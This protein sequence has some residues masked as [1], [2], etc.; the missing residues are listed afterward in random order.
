MEFKVGDRVRCIKEYVGKIPLDLCGTVM[1][2]GLDGISVGVEWDINIGGHDGELYFKGKAGYCY[3]IPKYCIKNITEKKYPTIII[4][5]DG[6]T[7][8]AMLRQ[9]KEVIR[10][11]TAKCNPAD[12]FDY[13]VGARLALDRLMQVETKSVKVATVREVKRKAK[14]GEW[15]K[16]TGKGDKGIYE[17]GDVLKVIS[18]HKADGGGVYVRTTVNGK[19]GCLFSTS[20]VEQPFAYLF[21]QEYLVLDGYAP[22]PEVKEVK[23]AAKVGEWIKVTDTG[24][25]SKEKGIY[26]VTRL[27]EHSD[28]WVLIDK[29][30]LIRKDQYVVLEN[31]D[32][33]T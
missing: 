10:T 24:G 3:F 33:K 7:T 15:I 17:H 18:V 29:L 20:L 23:R 28:G 31:Y 25:H 14:V 11:A 13:A 21:N 32:P 9:G 26:K 27:S 8:T 12:T 16:V 22:K 19:N 5:T 4:K 2:A 1:R 30:N 6:T